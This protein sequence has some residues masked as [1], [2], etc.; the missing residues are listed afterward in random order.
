MRLRQ[1]FEASSTEN[2]TLHFDDG[3]VKV[4]KDVPLSA[5]NQENF[6]DVLQDNARRIYDRDLVRY[7]REEEFVPTNEEIEWKKLCV[8]LY[9]FIRQKQSEI[10]ENS[11]MSDNIRYDYTTPNGESKV[12]EDIKQ[13]FG[14]TY[15]Y[16]T[17]DPETDQFGE[18]NSEGW[19]KSLADM[20]DLKTK[21][22]NELSA[23]DF[24][25]VGR[26]PQEAS[27]PGGPLRIEITGV[28]FQFKRELEE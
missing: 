23:E 22:I 3:T 21:V 4:I 26:P 10:G 13:T 17:I 12:I 14:I 11:Y 6:F 7:T 2:I 25:T 15:R 19:P 27:E 28:S 9:R 1:L 24:I 20:D 5:I 8:N 16:N 18:I